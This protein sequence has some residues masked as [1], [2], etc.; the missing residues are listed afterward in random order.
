MPIDIIIDPNDGGSQYPQFSLATSSFQQSVSWSALQDPPALAPFTLSFYKYNIINPIIKWEIVYA[1]LGMNWLNLTGVSVSGDEI[2][3]GTINSK[4]LTPV[5]VGIS[6]LPDGNYSAEIYFNSFDGSVSYSTI[7]YLISLSIVD[8]TIVSVNVDKS[9]Y[10]VVYNRQTGVLSGDTVVQIINNPNSETFN[11]K[12]NHFVEKLGVTTTF[13][14][15][16]LDIATNPNLPN[17]GTVNLQGKLIKNLS[18]LK[19]FNISLV[20]VGSGDLITDKTNISFTLYKSTAQTG[21]T[22][23]VITNPENKSFTIMAPSWLTLSET[24]GNSSKTISVTTVDSNMIAAGYYTGN[25]VISYEGKTVVIAVELLVISF[26]NFIQTPTNKFCLDIPKVTFIKMINESVFVR[27]TVTATYTVL[28]VVTIKEN[29]YFIPYSSNKA[30]FDLGEKVHNH[31]P[32]YK[33]DYFDVATGTELFKEVDVKILAEEL[34]ANYEVKYSETLSNIK[35]LPGKKPLA[36]PLLSNFLFRKRNRKSIF[37]NAELVNDSVL[38]RKTESTSNI[39]SIT[40]QGTE[41]KYYELPSQFNQI[42]LHFE[43]GNFAPEWFTLTG[44]FK[45]TNDV[46]HV[47]AKNIFKAQNEKYDVSKVKTLSINT[48]YYIK[49]ELKLINE[50]VESTLCYVI[51]EGVK[52]RCFATT[53]KLSLIDSTEEVLDRDLEFLIVE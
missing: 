50:M 35:L 23:F 42:H 15:E 38:F 16:S 18:V 24:S 52:Y 32:K 36:Y 30:E 29:I 13:N 34:D 6:N 10:N 40:Y 49:E 8:N 48:G 17:H 53:T 27:I 22:S 14:L 25:I 19:F 39:D 43:N 37:L 20:I 2:T 12:A 1:Q 51:I 26:I 31:F 11:F 4:T 33:G 3:V 41:V 7:S 47:Y 9:Q 45:I 46:S 5:L 44:E 21:N 28:G